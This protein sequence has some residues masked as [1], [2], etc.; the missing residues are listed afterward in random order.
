MAFQGEYFLARYGAEAANRTPPIR[1]MLDLGIPV[2]AGTDATR[3]S[4]YN[5]WLALYWLVSGRTIAGTALQSD[6]NRLDRQEALEL[7]TLGSSW[8][9]GESGR[10]GALAV[11]QLADLA[12]LSDDYFLVA[13][14]AIKDIQSVLTVVDGKVVHAAAEFAS[15]HPT[16]LPVLP[17]WSPVAAYG[18]YGAPLDVRNARRSGVPVLSMQGGSAVQGAAMGASHFAEFWGTGCDCSSL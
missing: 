11:G 7:Y 15:L 2:G 12:V 1:R 14:E 17:E 18:G 4:S 5:P 9:S 8:F 10:K 13:E 3:V 6:A 16:P